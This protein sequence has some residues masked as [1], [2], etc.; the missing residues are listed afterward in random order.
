MISRLGIPHDGQ[1]FPSTLSRHH[2][3]ERHG[4]H[5]HLQRLLPAEPAHARAHIS[6]AALHSHLTQGRR[7]ASLEKCALPFQG[8]LCKCQLVWF[9]IEMGLLATGRLTVH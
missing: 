1:L 2:V 9:P 5:G 4:V 3:Q 8:V 7:L 6:A